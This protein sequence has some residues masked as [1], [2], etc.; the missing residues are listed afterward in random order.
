MWEI[1]G[2][3]HL[4]V[5][6]RQVKSNSKNIAGSSVRSSHSLRLTSTE[7]AFFVQVDLS[8]PNVILGSRR[9]MI[10]RRKHINGLARAFDL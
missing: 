3:S 6:I 9:D 4:A 10:N 8:H 7:S 5:L 2:T 1:Q